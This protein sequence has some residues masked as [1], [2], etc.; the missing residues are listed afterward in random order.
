MCHLMWPWG[1]IGTQQL[2]TRVGDELP[3]SAG[4]P[5][6]CGEHRDPNP[7]ALGPPSWFSLAAG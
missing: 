1:T 3:C 2:H 6:G 5:L 7:A 4:L